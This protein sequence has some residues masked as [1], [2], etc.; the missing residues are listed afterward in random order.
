LV[1]INLDQVTS[2]RSDTEV[3][4]A[5]AQFDLTSGKFQGVKESV[6]QVMELIVTSR[7][8]GETDAAP[9]AALTR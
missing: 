5:R 2:V 4:G 8:T 9:S 6:E 3:P 1:Y 7:G